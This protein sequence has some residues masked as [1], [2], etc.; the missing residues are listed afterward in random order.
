MRALSGPCPPDKE[1]LNK[2][3][4]WHWWRGGRGGAPLLRGPH[5]TSLS[6]A[7]DLGP[8]SVCRVTAAEQA[9]PSGPV[10]KSPSAFDKTPK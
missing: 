2:V 8:S 10:S 4:E 9:G 7:A 6:Q 3:L 5:A 1:T